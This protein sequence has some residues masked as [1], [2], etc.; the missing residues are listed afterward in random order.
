[1]DRQPTD[2]LEQ[3]DR[4]ADECK[5][6]KDDQAAG[7]HKHLAVGKLRADREY[8]KAHRSNEESAQSQSK[9]HRTQACFKDE[10]L[11]EKRRLET[12][13]ENGHEPHANERGA[14]PNGPR[15][16]SAQLC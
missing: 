12:L 14:F 4:R 13:A 10:R 8:R 3:T 9:K 6:H 5:E 2:R 15:A 11:Q 16:A 7:D 1:M